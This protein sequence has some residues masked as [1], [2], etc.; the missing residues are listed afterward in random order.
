MGGTSMNQL[1]IKV[2]GEVL[3][4]NFDEWKLEL[5]GEIQAVNTELKTDA[6][7]AHAQIDVKRFK[8][9]AKSYS[10]QVDHVRNGVRII[11][12]CYCQKAT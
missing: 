3:S 2:R 6:Q 4:S 9:A 10:V 1:A 7:F 12:W 11:V 5:I 8:V